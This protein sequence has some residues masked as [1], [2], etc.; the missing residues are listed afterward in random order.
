MILGQERPRH[1]SSTPVAGNE[2]FAE[3]FRTQHA[4]LDD[5]YPPGHELKNYVP[6]KSLRVVNLPDVVPKVCATDFL[7]APL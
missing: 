3:V 6:L 4:E 2:A 5:D 1:H 7:H